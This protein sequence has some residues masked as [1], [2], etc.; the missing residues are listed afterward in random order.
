MASAPDGA[1]LAMSMLGKVFV[2]APA[3]PS[4]V[5]R[6]CAGSN[7][8][9]PARGR[10]IARGRSKFAPPS[11]ERAWKNTPSRV[12]MSVPIHTT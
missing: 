8:P 5:N 3:M 6:P 4:M 7:W 9:M 11:K 2:R 12:P 10:T 1:P